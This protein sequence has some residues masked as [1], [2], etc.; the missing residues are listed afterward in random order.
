[1][2]NPLT[3][4]TGSRLSVV[5]LLLFIVAF[6]AI[7][8][9]IKPQWEDVSSME[10]G[11]D[12]LLQERKTTS[13]KLTELQKLQQELNLASEVSKETTLS[14]I[15]ET[16]DQDELIRE[17]SDIAQKND[18]LLNS[19]NFS[20]PASKG[21]AEITQAQVNMNITGSQSDL[22]SLLRT[23]EGSTRKMLVRNI[24]VQL[25][26]ATLGTRVNFNL[27]AEVYYQGTI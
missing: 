5:A 24:S 11:R 20:I 8:F 18:M 4:K 6:A 25:G 19:V 21:G 16:L 27:T 7:W 9:Y 10:K 14:A 26:D 3:Q 22:I 13:E 1:M 23:I 12:E 2:K 15:P 17:L